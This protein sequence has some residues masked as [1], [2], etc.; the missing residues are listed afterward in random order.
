MRGRLIAPRVVEIAQLDS[1]ATTEGPPGVNP[2]FKEP[3]ISYDANGARTNGR[4]ESLIRLHAQIETGTY[5]KQRM[6]TTGNAPAAQL[7]LVFHF[8]ELEEL[9]LVDQEGRATLRVNDRLVAIYDREGCKIL[10]SFPNPPGL[11][12]TELPPAAFGFGDTRNLLVAR[13]GD[14]AQAKMGG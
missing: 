9:G 6:Q 3:R 11:Y 14:R 12:I 2:I 7:T 5:E 1:Q 8:E 10:Q 4:K 13:L